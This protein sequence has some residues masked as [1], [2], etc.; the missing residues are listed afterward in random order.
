[1]CSI[2]YFPYLIDW[3]QSENKNELSGKMVYEK[4]YLEGTREFLGL[5]ISA[6]VV[7]FLFSRYT[8]WLASS[9]LKIFNKT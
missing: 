5:I 3:L 4:F 2:P 9:K 7:A 8:N 6:L 1:M